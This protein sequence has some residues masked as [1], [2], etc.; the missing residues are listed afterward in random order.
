MGRKLSMRAAVLNGLC[1]L[2]LASP[3]LFPAAGRADE[4]TIRHR[5]T[6]LPLL[7]FVKEQA[8]FCTRSGTLNDLDL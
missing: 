7:F 8:A 1:C 2:G 6:N 4:V 3:V 5:A